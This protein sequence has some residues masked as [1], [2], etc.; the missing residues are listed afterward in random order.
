MRYKQEFQTLAQNLTANEGQGE[1]SM[2]AVVAKERLL[3]V[4]MQPIEA[5]PKLRQ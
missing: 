1:D 2:R 3:H 5:Y 4:L